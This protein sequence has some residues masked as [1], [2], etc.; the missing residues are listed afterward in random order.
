LASIALVTATLLPV[1]VTDTANAATPTYVTIMF[2]R[3]QYEGVV[4]PN[5]T[6]VPNAVT[7][8]RVAQDLAAHGYAATE[9][10]S[11]S[12]EAE[13]GERCNA[14]GDLTLGWSDLRPLPSQYGW[15]ITGPRQSA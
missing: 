14:N 10:V 2:S 11:T 9:A 12:L 4:A 1:L 6:P 3:A 7:I 8:W 5:C 13:T 15:A